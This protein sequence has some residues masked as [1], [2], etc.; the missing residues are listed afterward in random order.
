MALR[1]QLNFYGQ[2]Y[3]K[4]PKSAKVTNQNFQ[5]QT[6]FKK[7]KFD[8]FGFAQGQMG[9]LMCLTDA[10]SYLGPSFYDPILPGL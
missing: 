8:L 3:L 10:A 5:G 6:P 4:R 2:T 9:T 7:A 1:P